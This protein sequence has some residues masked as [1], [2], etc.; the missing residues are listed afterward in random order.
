MK[1]FLIILAVIVVIVAGFLFAKSSPSGVN[2]VE[3]TTFS[4]SELGLEFNYKAGSDGYVLE[5][6]SSSAV[7]SGPMKTLVL[8]RSED[9]LSGVPVGGEGPPTITLN[10]FD[11]KNKQWPQ[12]WVDTHTQYSNINLKIT[13]PVETSIG[14]AKAIRYM[15]D[16]LYVSDNVVITHGDSVYMVSGMFLEEDSNLRR[17]FQPLLDSIRFIPKP[18]QETTVGSYESYSADKL[19]RAD[20][21]DVVLFFKA[22]WCPTCQVAD[23][24]IK[25]NRGNI[26]ANLS[27][28]EVDY[29]SSQDLK[30]KYGVIYQHTFVQVDKGGNLIKKWSGSSTLS[31]I[32]AQVK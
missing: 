6:M 12:T 22:S 26:P 8:T 1:K 32:V 19:T 2:N 11:N 3:L 21:G 10:I 13:N 31:A 7:G 24:D 23:A 30:K 17:D 5:E 28:L 16:G 27:I 4:S 20:S 9:K 15:A 14:G 29:D 25:A 18:G